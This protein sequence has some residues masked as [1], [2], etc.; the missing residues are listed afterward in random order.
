MEKINKM[1][2]DAYRLF[3]EKHFN[4]SLERLKKLE[5]LFEDSQ[6]DHKKKDYM[7]SSLYNFMGFNYLALDKLK[8]SKTV[9]EKALNLYPASSQAC[10]GLGEILFLVN[11]DR[12]SKT[13]YEWAL[14]N[15]PKNKFALSGLAKVNLQLEYPLEH[16]SLTQ[17]PNEIEEKRLDE[18][19]KKAFSFLQEKEF[20]QALEVIEMVQSDTEKTLRDFELLLSELLGMKGFALLGLNDMENAKH[21]FEIA[22]SLNPESALAESLLEHKF[23]DV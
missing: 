1:L 9:F 2:R 5:I 13:M 19:F 4:E 17:K 6:K 7:L 10:A 16:N 23:S 21:S 20:R 11:M 12:E 14:Y 22:L 8:D 18:L 3:Y 15:N